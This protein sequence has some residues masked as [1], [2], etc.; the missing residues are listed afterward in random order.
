MDDEVDPVLEEP[1]V[2]EAVEGQ[3]EVLAAKY[4]AKGDDSVSLQESFQSMT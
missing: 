3:L 4:P 1:D 2:G